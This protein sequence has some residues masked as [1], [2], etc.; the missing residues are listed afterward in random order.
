MKTLLFIALAA[1]ILGLLT[2]M[3]IIFN[4]VFTKISHFYVDGRWEKFGI[5]EQNVL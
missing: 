1:A 4:L 5:W 2:S 3:L